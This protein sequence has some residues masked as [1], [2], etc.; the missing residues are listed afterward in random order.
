MTGP[1][2][3]L[4]IEVGDD[5]LALVGEIDAH[6]VHVVSEALLPLPIIGDVRLDLDGVTFI[7]SSG[8][9]VILDVHR[10]MAADGRR[11]VLLRPSAS[12]IRLLGITGLT[13]HLYTEPPIETPSEAVV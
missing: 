10:Q 1:G 12:V 4:H 7:D 2:A 6:T 3:P 8:I 5:C 9:R 11:L 13:G